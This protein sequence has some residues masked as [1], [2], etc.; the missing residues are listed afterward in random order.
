MNNFTA[1]STDHRENN[2]RLIMRT[3]YRVYQC[4]R[5]MIP[6]LENS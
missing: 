4:I 1:N 5:L 3:Q 6:H 2:N